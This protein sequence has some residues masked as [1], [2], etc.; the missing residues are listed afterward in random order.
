LFVITKQAGKWLQLSLRNFQIFQID[1]QWLYD[2]ASQFARWQHIVV[3][4]ARF[5]VPG[6]YI[7]GAGQHLLIYSFWFC[8][9]VI[10]AKKTPML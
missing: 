3:A 10:L 9:F 2:D 7:N 1:W 8:F 6:K 5:A 4:R